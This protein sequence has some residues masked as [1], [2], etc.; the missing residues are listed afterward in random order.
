MTWRDR[1]N[2]YITVVRPAM[3][4][5][6]VTWA[7]KKACEKKLV[8]AEIKMLRWTCVVLQRWTE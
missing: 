5:G 1:V 8:V 4:Y 2:V 7:A 3:I 6:A